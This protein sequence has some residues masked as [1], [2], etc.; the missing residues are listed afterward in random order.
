M[1]KIAL[2]AFLS[3]VFATPALADNTGKFYG[4][5]D[6]GSATYN[7]MS[8]FPNPGAFRIS[9]GY[10]YSPV[11]SAEVGYTKFGDSTITNG[12]NSAT[13][14]ASSLQIAAVAAFPLASQFD[15]L[16]KFGI[17]MNSGKATNTF[18]ASASTSKTDLYFALGAQ[19]HINTQLSVRAQYEN[20]GKFEN[21]T[22]P[23]SASVISAGVAYDF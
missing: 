23:M 7:N 16:G 15:V 3:A 13:V 1:K 14:S 4:A 2:V 19:Y 21:A 20:M 18:G 9:G 10:H 11:V 8:P 22:N 17:A 12:F 6:L 5:I